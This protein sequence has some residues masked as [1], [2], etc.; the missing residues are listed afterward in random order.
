M[1]VDLHCHYVPGID[2]GVRTVGE[3]LELCRGL[4]R[5]G[6]AHVVATPH[7]RTAMF[8]NRPEDVAAAFG[9]FR[10]R[11]EGE[12]ELPALDHAAEHF[13]DDVFA[14]AFAEGRF[15][16]YPGGH[17]MLLELPSET[18]PVRLRQL[19]FQMRLRGVTPVLAHPERYTAVWRSSDELEELVEAGVL[20]LLDVMALSER[21]GREPRRAAERLL[22]DGLYF[23]AC[24]DAHKPSDVEVVLDA[25]ARLRRLVG[26]EE[27]DEL[28]G[29]HPRR[30]L[31]G[32]FE[33][34]LSG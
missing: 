27:A 34:W 14:A 2:D 6:F 32:T 5:A 19:V 11:A 18:V 1:Y 10:D 22:D 28:L 9:A 16:A 4:R 33:Q 24:S 13:C 12:P 8:D 3:G 31:A 29:E 7:I 25:M 15:V 26:R 30:V 17:A 23:A 21:Y 20:P